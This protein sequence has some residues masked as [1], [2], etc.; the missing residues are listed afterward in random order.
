MDR[1][2][3][4][5]FDIYH[6]LFPYKCIIIPEITCACLEKVHSLVLKNSVFCLDVLPNDNK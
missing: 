4:R 3:S 1:N 2:R 6:V 5:D